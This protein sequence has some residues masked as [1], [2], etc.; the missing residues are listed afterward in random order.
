MKKTLE[1]SE[2]THKLREDARKTI[3]ALGDVQ[4]RIADGLAAGDDVEEA[5]KVLT[6][7]YARRD[8][9]AAKLGRQREAL[10]NSV[11]EDAKAAYDHAVDLAGQC[12]AKKAAL[13]DM[14]R[15]QVHSDVRNDAA[16]EK[17]SADSRYWPGELRDADAELARAMQDMN[18]AARRMA[19]VDWATYTAKRAGGMAFPIGGWEGRDAFWNRAAVY[20]P[21]LGTLAPDG[22]CGTQAILR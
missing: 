4:A 6:P 3:E 7:M 21:E 13:R 9:L 5:T 1:L 15:R 10:F 11:V 19:D 14:W 20:A 22:P 12:R 16:R 8:V 17:L 2:T 18:P